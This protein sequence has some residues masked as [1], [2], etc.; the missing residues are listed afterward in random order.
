MI[1]LEKK[2]EQEFCK[3]VKTIGGTAVKFADP[4]RPG[5]PDRIVLLPHGVA[6]FVEFKRPGKAP[7]ENQK[8]WI[9]WL[10]NRGFAAIVTDNAEE[11]ITLIKRILG[12]AV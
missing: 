4:S 8:M 9:N 12:H 7:R 2:A 3:W 5:A 1:D 10:Q 6:V 11:P